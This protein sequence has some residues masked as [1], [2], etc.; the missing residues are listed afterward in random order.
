MEIVQGYIH[1]AKFIDSGDFVTSVSAEHVRTK[2]AGYATIT[3]RNQWPNPG[4]P[5]RIWVERGTRRGVRLRSGKRPFSKTRTRL[6]QV[7][8]ERVFAEPLRKVL[9]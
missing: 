2:G 7:S 5:P 9:N 1:Q 6:R 4:R 8:I 3:A